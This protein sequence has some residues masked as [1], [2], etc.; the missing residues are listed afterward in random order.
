MRKVLTIRTTTIES[1]RQLIEADDYDDKPWINEDN[2]INNIKGVEFSNVKA[3][4]GTFGHKVI[5]DSSKY[6]TQTGYQWKNF[7]FTDQQARPLLKHA[8]EHPLWVREVPLA[9]LY[10]TPQFDLIITGTTDCIEGMQ[11]RDT[12]FKF[13]TFEVSDFLDSF[14]W[15]AYLD[16]VGL[17][18]F[19]YDF[20]R[21]YGFE[22]IEDCGKARID[23][24][25]SMPVYRY[26][27]MQ[28]DLQDTINSFAD[29]VTVKG[30]TGYMGLN[31]AKIRRIVSGNSSLRQYCTI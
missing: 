10:H 1:F 16:M 26:D 23:E 21:V 24:C 19:I 15:R 14:Q 4:Y 9:K 5:E 25:E 31:E 12:K 20:F 22:S 2:V 13:S 6:A 30:L 29:F 8:S 17:D 18:T 28:S 11:L 27:G 7:T 3:D